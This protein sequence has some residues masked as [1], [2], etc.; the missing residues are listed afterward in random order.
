MS[1]TQRI[2]KLLFDIAKENKAFRVAA[3][4]TRDAFYLAK[5][6]ADAPLCKIDDKLVYFQTCI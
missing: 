3:R 4:G 6:T 5:M 2:K 1:A